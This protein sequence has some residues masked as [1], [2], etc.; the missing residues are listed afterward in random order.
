MDCIVPGVAKSQ[1]QLGDLLSLHFTPCYCYQDDLLPE[2]CGHSAAN[3]RLPSALTIT[4]TVIQTHAG[5]QREELH[6]W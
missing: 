3:W 4:S 1:T 2:M 5:S 6:P